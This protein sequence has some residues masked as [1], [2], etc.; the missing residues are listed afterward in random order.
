[1]EFDDFYSKLV[2][3]FGVRMDEELSL[4][5]LWTFRLKRL[6]GNI[7]A[8]I[9]DWSGSTTQFTVN[10]ALDRYPRNRGANI[11]D[12]RQARLKEKLCSSAISPL[13]QFWSTVFEDDGHPVLLSDL[14]CPSNGTNQVPPFDGLVRYVS[15]RNFSRFI[16]NPEFPDRDRN[17]EWGNDVA[18]GSKFARK[19]ARRTNEIGD[20]DNVLITAGQI[21]RKIVGQC[22]TCFAT[23]YIP[24]NIPDPADRTA[25]NLAAREV[26]QKLA[27]PGYE[28]PEMR[29]RSGGIIAITLPKEKI[30]RLY[31]PTILEAWG[32][33]GYFFL[34]AETSEKH[35]RTAPLDPKLE[36]NLF[37][38]G[39]VTTDTS[40][41]E[42]MAVVHPSVVWKRG[43]VQ[44]IGVFGEAP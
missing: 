38:F 14:C 19:L 20:A 33:M 29:R 4:E 22:A 31:K 5:E 44:I 3:S 10:L 24:S 37:A 11:R 17:Q 42:W 35:G 30:Y 7:R 15:F 39:P 2:N 28:T 41:K 34:P 12:P 36:K 43:T 21:K 40:V 13:P 25:S 23:N 18:T 1:M 26:V 9:E 27:L 6:L 8:D 16:E 32:E